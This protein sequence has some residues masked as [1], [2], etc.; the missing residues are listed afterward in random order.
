MPSVPL[1]GLPPNGCIGDKYRLLFDFN[2][3]ICNIY[4]NELPANS[5]YMLQMASEF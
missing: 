5:I 4:N 3:G 2:F 1:I